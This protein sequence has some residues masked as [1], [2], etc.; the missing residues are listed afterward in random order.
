[1]EA[2]KTSR[3]QLLQTGSKKCEKKLKMRKE[4]EVEVTVK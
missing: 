4:V 1:M 2:K 3:F